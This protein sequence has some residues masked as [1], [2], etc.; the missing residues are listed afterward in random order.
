MYYYYPLG[1]ILLQTSNNGCFQL[2][3]HFQQKMNYLFHGFDFL[4]VHRET[5]GIN[6]RTLDRS[7]TKTLIKSK[8]LDK[9]KWNI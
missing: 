6:K 3:R 1:K 5:F 8:Y 4:C 2:T 7:C 9:P